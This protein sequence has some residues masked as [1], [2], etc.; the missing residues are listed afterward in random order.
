MRV[1]VREKIIG[2]TYRATWVSSASNPSP[3][4]SA[5]IDK[6]EVVVS[7]IAAIS[8]GNGFFYALHQ[9]PT[10]PGFYTNEWRAVVGSYVYVNRQIV[11]LNDPQVD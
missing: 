4:T 5:L 6:H 2:D 1:N 9:L 8:S 11:H 10:T 3:I 7:S